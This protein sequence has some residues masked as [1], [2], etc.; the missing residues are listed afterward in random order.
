VGGNGNSP[1]V[2]GGGSAPGGVSANSSA[3]QAPGM[4]FQACSGALRTATIE[5]L[6]NLHDAGQAWGH[7]DLGQAFINGGGGK[8]GFETTLDE[9]LAQ[10]ADMVNALEYA[11]KA[12]VASGATFVQTELAV[13]G[14]AA[15]LGATPADVEAAITKAIAG[16]NVGQPFKISPLT[17]GAARN[18]EPPAS[19]IQIVD[20]IEELT[21][22]RAP[23]GSQAVLGNIEQDLGAMSKTIATVQ[24]GVHV[25][26]SATTAVN[27]GQA[28]SSFSRFADELTRALAWLAEACQGLGMSAAN[29]QAVKELAWRQ[30]NQA[31]TFLS[32][33][34]ATLS[35]QA[36]SNMSGAESQFDALV[37]EEG[38][39]LLAARKILD[40]D[41]LAGLPA[42]PTSPVTVWQGQA[43]T[44]NQRAASMFG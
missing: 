4:E 41:V 36:Q 27:Q 43:A 26:A 12:M 44:P 21:P 13:S 15:S 9:V 38:Q 42:T 31:V 40:S 16:V 22:Y 39:A 19:W 37:R 32:R 10:I 24:D 29:L 30:L 33:Q 8:P 34:Q 7:D 6:A 20:L 18:D 23:D 3:W 17:L 11:G 25:A 28:A 1:V 35:V 5:L 2:G 14:S